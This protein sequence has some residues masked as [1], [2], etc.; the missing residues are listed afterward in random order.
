VSVC[1]FLVMH[2]SSYVTPGLYLLHLNTRNLCK[3]FWG[4]LWE[5]S[6]LTSGILGFKKSPLLAC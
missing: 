1:A 3:S 6:W 4:P 5:D 2:F